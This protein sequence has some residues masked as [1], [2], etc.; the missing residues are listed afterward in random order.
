MSCRSF[1][2]VPGSSLAKQFGALLCI[3]REGRFG[4]VPYYGE[5]S[6]IKMADGNIR[7]L[8]EIANVIFHAAEREFGADALAM[9]AG[10][11]PNNRIRWNSQRRALLTA[12]KTKLDGITNRHAEVGGSVSTLVKALGALTFL[13]QTDIENLKAIK[14]AE[15]GNFEFDLGGSL[16]FST[17]RSCFSIA[18]WASARRRTRRAMLVSPSFSLRGRCGYSVRMGISHREPRNMRL[19]SWLNPCATRSAGRPTRHG[20]QTALPTAKLSRSRN[21]RPSRQSPTA[22]RDAREASQPVPANPRR[23]VRMR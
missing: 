3:T 5:E 16:T 21:D 19:W 10:L 13:L 22:R 18:A 1:L 8:L 12:S 7:E 11:K 23:F 14:T 17:L 15:R 4:S 9:F 20:R 6:L 2:V